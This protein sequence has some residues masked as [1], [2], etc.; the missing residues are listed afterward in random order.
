MLRQSLKGLG[1]DTN[2]LLEMAEI[3]PNLRA[4]E[5]EVHDFVRLA[6]SLAQLRSNSHPQKNHD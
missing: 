4:E 5:I 1:A 3:A 2:T 6:N